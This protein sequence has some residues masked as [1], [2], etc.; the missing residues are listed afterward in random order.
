[1]AA[2]RLNKWDDCMNPRLLIFL[3][4]DRAKPIRLEEIS[5]QKR[6]WIS[7]IFFLSLDKRKNISKGLRVIP[8]GYM[9]A[10]EIK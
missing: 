2:N 6:G 8:I 10:K 7:E 4:K 3:K 5:N 9:G 1:M